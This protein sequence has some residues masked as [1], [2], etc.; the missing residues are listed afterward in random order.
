VNYSGK[1]DYKFPTDAG[2]TGNKAVMSDAMLR[3][4]ISVMLCRRF[5]TW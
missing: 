5:S 4:K 1:V 2:L 3:E